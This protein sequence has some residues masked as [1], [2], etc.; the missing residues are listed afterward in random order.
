VSSVINGVLVE[1]GAAILLALAGIV[2]VSYVIGKNRSN[3]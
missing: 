3:K 1:T 2:Y